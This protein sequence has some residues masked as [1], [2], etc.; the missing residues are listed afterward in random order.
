MP[1]NTDDLA[2]LRVRCIELKTTLDRHL[3][4]NNESLIRIANL[5][6]H[7]DFLLES[8]KILHYSRA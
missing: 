3:K 6:F 5:K 1:N 8:P 2:K 4:E 7:I